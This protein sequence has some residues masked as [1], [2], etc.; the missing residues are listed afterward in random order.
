VAVSIGGQFGEQREDLAFVVHA[1]NH[2]G[3]VHRQGLSGT[4]AAL[5]RQQLSSLGLGQVGVVVKQGITTSLT[6]A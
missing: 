3:R 6:P 4:A 1:K 2:G 5:F